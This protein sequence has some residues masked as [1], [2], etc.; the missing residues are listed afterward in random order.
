MKIIKYL[1]IVLILFFFIT[2]YAKANQGCCSWHGGISHCGDNGYYI[3][4]DGTQSP[5]CRCQSI[6][7]TDTSCN[8]EG[9]VNKINSLMSEK[10]SLEREITSLKEEKQKLKNSES[11]YKILFWITIIIFIIYFYYKNHKKERI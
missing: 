7:L 11:N 1:L 3:C 5:S 6:E 9:Y 10:T 8:Y 4:E 2:P